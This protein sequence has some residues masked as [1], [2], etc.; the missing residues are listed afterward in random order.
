MVNWNEYVIQFKR[1]GD[2]FLKDKTFDQVESDEFLKGIS[3]YFASILSY[4]F[5]NI[6]KE[7]EDRN[8]FRGIDSLVKY[9]KNLFSNPSPEFQN[10]HCFILL[11]LSL[12]YNW[13]G[14]LKLKAAQKASHVYMKSDS[15]KAAPNSSESASKAAELALKAKSAISKAAVAVSSSS[16]ESESS[17]V[18]S[19]V[20]D[21][22]VKA[23]QSA[24][25]ADSCVR[26][27]ESSVKAAE[28]ARNSLKLIMDA[29]N[30]MDNSETHWVEVCRVCR[31]DNLTVRDW[32]AVNFPETFREFD[33]N[34]N[35]NMSFKGIG[36]LGRRFLKEFTTQQNL[37]IDLSIFFL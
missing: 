23:S 34:Q 31:V 9:M 6:S 4:I 36:S 22:A 21:A 18:K 5:E 10:V 26:A 17:Y 3:Y 32:L 37:D 27:S 19:A 28:A 33:I 24:K 12:L 16:S 1:K 29:A 20:E 15:V 30:D 11:F 14:R 2:H 13:S 35:M 7:K 25:A 8:F